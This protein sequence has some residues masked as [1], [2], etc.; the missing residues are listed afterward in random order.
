MK[1]CGVHK[2]KDGCRKGRP[3]CS[4]RRKA[5]WGLCE[6]GAYPFPHRTGGGL[7]NPSNMNA[8]LYG[9]VPS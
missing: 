1:H 6:C 4:I 7:C 3:L 9:P 5:R 8:M 2:H